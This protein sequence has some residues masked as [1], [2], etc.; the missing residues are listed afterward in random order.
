MTY[1]EWE[2]SQFDK[3]PSEFGGMM[4]GG[5]NSSPP[6]PPPPRLATLLPDMPDLGGAIYNAF[7][8]TEDFL[9]PRSTTHPSF[10]PMGGGRPSFS[11]PP[12]ERPALQMPGLTN[13]LNTREETMIDPRA[14]IPLPGYRNLTDRR[15][16]PPPSLRKDLS[17]LRDWWIRTGYHEPPNFRAMP[18][19][20]SGPEATPYPRPP[21][22][23]FRNWMDTGERGPLPLQSYRPGGYPAPANQQMPEVYDTLT[24]GG[25]LA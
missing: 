16:V 13:F 15:V 23:N 9:R 17:K 10:A 2:K 5:K 12:G 25:A 20:N 11:V 6:L 24:S 22:L 8:R 14:T 21:W 7:R 18:K 19:M 3:N 4:L 1:D